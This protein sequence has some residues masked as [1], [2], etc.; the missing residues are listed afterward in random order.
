APCLA[1]FGAATRFATKRQQTLECRNPGRSTDMSINA[2]IFLVV[3]TTAIAL[4]CLRLDRLAGSLSEQHRLY[5]YQQALR[6]GA[7]TLAIVA[8]LVFVLCVYGWWST[9]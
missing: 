6:V 7:R 3:L 5:R 8:L 9:N 4:L 1:H 2:Y